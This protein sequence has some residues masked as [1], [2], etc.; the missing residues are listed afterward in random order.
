M[1]DVGATPTDLD[2][3]GGGSDLSPGDGLVR[4]GSGVAAVE[5]AGC[6]EEHGVVG[7]VPL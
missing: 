2:S 5:L 3:L 7:T 6:V 4:S 1:S